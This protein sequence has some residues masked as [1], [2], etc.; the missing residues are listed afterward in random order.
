VS[1]KKY[2]RTFDLSGIKRISKYA[3]I[4]ILQKSQEKN[5]KCKML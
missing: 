3:I 2:A 1:G 5:K 4:G